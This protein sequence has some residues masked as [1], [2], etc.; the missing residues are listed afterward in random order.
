M[1]LVRMGARQGPWKRFNSRRWF[2]IRGIWFKVYPKERS[3]HVFQAPL[4][5]QEHG[6]DKNPKDELLLANLGNSSSPKSMHSRWNDYNRC[7]NMPFVY[8]LAL[9]EYHEL[10]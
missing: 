2:L 9:L 6:D 7:T 10:I 4:I 8:Q 5:V 3:I 1:S